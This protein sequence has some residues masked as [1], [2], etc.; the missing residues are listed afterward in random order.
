M[1]GPNEEVDLV[2]EIKAAAIEIMTGL[3]EEIGWLDQ[4]EASE[5]AEAALED[6]EERLADLTTGHTPLV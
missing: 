6:L 5:L 1:M 3:V 2:A 4:P